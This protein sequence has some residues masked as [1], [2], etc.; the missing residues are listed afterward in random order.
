[1]PGDQWQK[2]A[3]LRAYLA[4]MC[5]RIRLGCSSWDPNSGNRRSGAKS[6]GSPGGFSTSRSTGAPHLVGEMNWVYRD[7][8]SLWS[9]DSLIPADQVDRCQ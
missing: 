1:M 6:V 5:G 7:Q 8:P 9:R 4:F 3:N 2:L